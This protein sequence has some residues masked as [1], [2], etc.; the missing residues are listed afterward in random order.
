M[1]QGAVNTHART[2]SGPRRRAQSAPQTKVQ[3]R[4]GSGSSSILLKKPALPRLQS[5]ARAY[6]GM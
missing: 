3:I 6:S 2:G 5:A 1:R 4:T